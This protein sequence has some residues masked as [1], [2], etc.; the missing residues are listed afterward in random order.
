[1]C[2]QCSTRNQSDEKDSFKCMIIKMKR[3]EK[4]FTLYMHGSSFLCVGLRI[5]FL[6]LF[7]GLRIIFLG[8]FVPHDSYFFS[9]VGGHW[10]KRKSMLFSQFSNS[11]VGYMGDQEVSKRVLIRSSDLVISVDGTLNTFK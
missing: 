1:M 8:L 3:E 7:V 6:G 9:S 4:N 11:F 10:C 5:I 2:F